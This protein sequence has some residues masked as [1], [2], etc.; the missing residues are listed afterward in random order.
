[1]IFENNAL[2]DKIKQKAYP[3]VIGGVTFNFILLILLLYIIFK[4]RCVSKA[5]D[6]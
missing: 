3:Y 4:L 2:K 6:I 1:M 5:L